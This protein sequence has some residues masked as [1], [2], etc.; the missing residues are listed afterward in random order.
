MVPRGTNVEFPA[1]PNPRETPNDESGSDQF[2]YKMNVRV[3]FSACCTFSF[4]ISPGVKRR[5][6]TAAAAL[7]FAC[8]WLDDRLAEWRFGSCRRFPLLTDDDDDEERRR[9]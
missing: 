1:H 9:R 3:F 6:A 4:I 8:V 5:G 2:R 7:G